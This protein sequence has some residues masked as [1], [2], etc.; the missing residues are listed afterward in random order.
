LAEV[1]AS[2]RS[3][4]VYAEREVPAATMSAMLTAAVQVTP[5]LSW[6]VVTRRV[7]GVTMGSH[8]VESQPS[9]GLRL[10]RVGP[11]PGAEA[12][13]QREFHLAPV[14]VVAMANL[15]IPAGQSAAPLYHLAGRAAHAAA[16][17]GAASGLESCLFYGPTLAARTTLR[18]DTVTRAPLIA[19]SAGLPLAI[20]DG[21]N[22]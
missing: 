7:Q 5:L 4:R 17:A 3:T 21:T 16:I 14:I 11:V 18:F 22:A 13:P 15:L 6:A 8:H 1:L 12:W 20:Q 19:L 9:F 10:H 2:R